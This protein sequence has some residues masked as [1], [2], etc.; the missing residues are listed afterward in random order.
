MIYLNI[1]R[2]GILW[3]HTKENGLPV[4]ERLAAQLR[5]HGCIITADLESAEL[6]GCKRIFPGRN[7]ECDILIVLG[8]DGTLLSTLDY[9][10]LCPNV[11]KSGGVFNV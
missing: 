11:Q 4:I 2:A 9:A 1:S 5:D 8:G 10:I 6:L 3:N 7:P